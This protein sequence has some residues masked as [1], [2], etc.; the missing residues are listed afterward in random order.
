M[1][2]VKVASK[3]F[4]GGFVI[5][6]KADFDPETHKLFVEKEPAQP[7]AEEP[8]RVAELLK[9]TKAE[10]V[11]LAE[12]IGVKVVPDELTKAQIVDAILAAQPED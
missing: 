10:L 3:D 9:Q 7:A 2:T 6:N 4:E 1:E 8:D 11:A 12:G 5:V